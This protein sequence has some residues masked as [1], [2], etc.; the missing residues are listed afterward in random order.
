MR[1][2]TRTR[3]KG[4]YT[5]ASTD[6]DKMRLLVEPPVLLVLNVAQEGGQYGQVLGTTA[7]R[8]K[9]TW[10][11]GDTL[12][13]LSQTRIQMRQVRGEKSPCICGRTRSWYVNA[14]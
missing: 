5:P 6:D 9:G 7:L 3:D 4:T 2:K 1:K 14:S 10:G 13:M 11:N 12:Y 8:L